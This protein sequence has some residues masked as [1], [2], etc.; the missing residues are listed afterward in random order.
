[1]VLTVWLWE[2]KFLVELLNIGMRL[3]TRCAEAR[4]GTKM[5]MSVIQRGG[6][7]TI[8]NYVI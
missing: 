7:T 1:M 6:D 5:T 8:I 3:V 4:P 2:F